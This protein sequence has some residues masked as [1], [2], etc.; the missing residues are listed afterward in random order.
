M[1]VIFK[2]SLYNA[3]F[4]Y[5]GFVIGAVNTLFLY[6]NFMT[7]EYNGLIGYMISVANILMPLLNCGVQ[8][9]MV[10]FY[11]YY[12]TDE[13]R[14]KFNFI[15][16]LLPWLVIIPVG[17][18]G[19]IG[20][21]FIAGFLSK[22]NAEITHYV[23]LI[24]IIA[25]SMAY[26]EVFY[27]WVKVQY[28]SVT[29]NFMKEVFH[30]AVVMIMLFAL[31]AKFLNIVQFIYGVAIMYFL[32]T[33]IML[34]VAYRIKKPDFSI[35]LPDQF[36]SVIKYSILIILAGSI[37]IVLLDIDKV[38]LGQ[39]MDLKNVAYY[40]VAVFIAIVIAVPSRAMQ[41]I[42]TPI[43]AKLLNENDAEGLKNLYKR[44]SLTL[45]I[46]S[47]V[48]FLLI[49]LNLKE[50]YTLL[51]AEYSKA[52][53]VVFLISLAKLS[54]NV[55][56]IN[57]AIIFN[58]RYYL[59]VLLFGVLLAMVTV[60]LNMVF[61]PVWGINGSALATLLSFTVYNT[62]KVAFVQ[63]K[64]KIQPFSSETL[65][66]TL[67]FIVIVPIFIFWEFPFHAIINIFLKSILILVCCI[68][69]ILKLKLSTDL[70]NIWNKY[71][72]L[73]RNYSR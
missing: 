23:W 52:T 1:G 70:E 5:I 10:K 28:K 16:F 33:V 66:S 41:Q 58:S 24:F 4:T 67:L 61:I 56:G 3:I 60:I 8:N 47:G 27:A 64:F 68:A 25:A 34:L 53:L 55:L 14:D 20:Y 9:A 19:W 38:M 46:V 37:A 29:G 62:V 72:G 13:E 32:R 15:M 40:N 26:F 63:W 71:Y 35:G 39:Y 45:Y 2:Q 21:D 11:S 65:K 44:S 69:G 12:K 49:V 59:M 17:I 36:K 50:L 22:Q 31:Y 51:P 7:D 6:T 42:T 43:T 48:V 73:I 54:E 18:L 30:R 57:N